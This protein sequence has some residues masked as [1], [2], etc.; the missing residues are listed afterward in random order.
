[1]LRYTTLKSSGS[2]PEQ[3]TPKD[4]TSGDE[5]LVAR[6]YEEGATWSHFEVTTDAICDVSTDVTFH[7]AISFSELAF[8]PPRGD[9]LI[10]KQQI[11]HRVLVM[12]KNER[13]NPFEQFFLVFGKY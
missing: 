6:S 10:P 7:R 13:T 12:C 9:Y 8:N 5:E 2:N 1:M 3:S 4:G 11:V